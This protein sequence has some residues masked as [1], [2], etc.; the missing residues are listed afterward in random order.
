V[1][2]FL[3]IYTA[4]GDYVTKDYYISGPPELVQ[5]RVTNIAL[6]MLRRTIL[7]LEKL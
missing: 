1:P 5:T 6:E 7:G 2:S 3:A 4:A